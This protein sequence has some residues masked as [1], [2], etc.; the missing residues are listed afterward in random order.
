MIH[1]TDDAATRRREVGHVDVERLVLP[2]WR[3]VFRHVSRAE[4]LRFEV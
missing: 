2:A 4:F 3:E 1:D